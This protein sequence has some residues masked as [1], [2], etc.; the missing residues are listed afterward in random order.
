M[1]GGF[2]SPRYLCFTKEVKTLV[3][4][5]PKAKTRTAHRDVRGS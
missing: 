1:R 5:D 3:K 4:N 2:F